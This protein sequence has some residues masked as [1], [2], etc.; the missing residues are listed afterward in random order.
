M[1][2]LLH[3]MSAP[4]A[5]DLRTFAQNRPGYPGL[6]KE[7]LRLPTRT[8]KTVPGENR[9]RAAV[10]FL[11]AGRQNQRNPPVPTPKAALSRGEI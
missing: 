7:M 9:C 5:T 6:N 3:N 11:G 8:G 10:D 2:T 4:S 1:T